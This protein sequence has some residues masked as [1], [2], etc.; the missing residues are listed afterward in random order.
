MSRGL[1]AG[2]TDYSHQSL[3]DVINDLEAETH[4]LR[5]SVDEIERNIEKLKSEGYW[6]SKVPHSFKS[7]IAYAIKHYNTSREEIVSILDEIS[8]Q[9]Q[10]HH[11]RRLMRIAEVADKI[12]RD[13]GIDWHQH[14]VD[15]DYGDP[16]FN[17]VEK[18]YSTTR[19]LAADLLDVSNMVGRLEDFIGKGS[20]TMSH[21]NPWIT[22]SFYL[23]AF[24]VV[25]TTL[26]VITSKLSLSVL[27]IVLIAGILYV[28]IIGAFQLRN[29]EKLD[30]TN[31]LRL[32][33]E[34]YRQLPLLRGKIKQKR[35]S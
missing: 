20:K 8:T 22:G 32:M 9:I 15:K 30:E 21:N 34:T 13:L 12:N 25:L 35:K 17:I 27:P 2:L 10:E 29:D 18:I 3:M 4:H 16:N 31:F 1:L 14:Y 6:E 24:I 11:C 26:S 5:E 23:V 19:G 7:S 28:G 33:A